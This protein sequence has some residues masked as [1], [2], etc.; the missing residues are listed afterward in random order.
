MP[1]SIESL[2]DLLNKKPQGG[3]SV[4]TDPNHLRYRPVHPESFVSKDG[5]LNSED[6]QVDGFLKAPQHQQAPSTGAR[7]LLNSKYMDSRKPEDGAAL[8]TAAPTGLTGAVAPDY[9][10]YS[11]L[12]KKIQALKPRGA[13]WAEILGGSVGAIGGM[14][15]G[16]GAQGFGTS[17]KQLTDL[18]AK[19]EKKNDDFEKLL[20]EL[21]AKRAAQMAKGIKGTKDSGDHWQ[22]RIWED[23]EGNQRVAQQKKEDGTWARLSTDPVRNSD[24]VKTITQKNADGSEKQFIANSSGLLAQDFGKLNPK[25]SLQQDAE[26]RLHGVN[27]YDV[28]NAKEVGTPSFNKSSLGTTKADEDTYTKK[29]VEFKKASEP[30][31]LA[32]NAA[33]KSLTA[34][35]KGDNAGALYALKEVVR[36]LEQG[37]MSDQDYIQV[38]NKLGPGWELWLE[39]KEE[40]ILN[41]KALS[42]PERRELKA[43]A[44]QLLEGARAEHTRQMDIYN[45]QI[46]KR[47]SPDEYARLKFQPLI[48]PYG[49]KEQKRQSEELLMLQEQYGSQNLVIVRDNQTGKKYWAKKPTA[50]GEKLKPI[51][52][53]EE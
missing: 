32:Y 48:K 51:K 15:A 12:E 42:D 52:E 35:D 30:S 44:T 14:V 28:S 7:S 38:A 36:A 11:D 9:S 6:I 16:V 29:E 40:A 39:K 19:N 5:T 31:A 3:M 27:Q 41:G 17:G 10:G 46:A 18:A 23:D 22:L 50:P 13:H 49:P 21:E 1:K 2:E 43:I 33:S 8:S 47:L 34:L 25:M 53:V 20:L 24:A 37:K 45:S 26:G 4:E